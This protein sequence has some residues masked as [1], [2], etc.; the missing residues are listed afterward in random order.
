M[1]ADAMAPSAR[2]P[3]P[4]GTN[5]LGRVTTGTMMFLLDV[6]SLAVVWPAAVLLAGVRAPSPT[7]IAGLLLFPV[8]ELLCL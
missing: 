7:A 4:G 6:A 5:L 3:L 8:F 1:F 2:K